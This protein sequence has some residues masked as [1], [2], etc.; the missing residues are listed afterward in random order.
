MKIVLI[1]PPVADPTA[2][3]IALPLLTAVLRRSGI[4]AVPV[5]V[6]VEAFEWLF[7]RETLLDAAGRIERRRKNLEKK[8]FLRHPEP[9]FLAALR[10]GGEIARGCPARVEAS[11]SLLREPGSAT[12]FEHDAYRKAVTALERALEMVSAAYTPLHVDF[13][14][15]RTPFS[16]LT[17]GNV[18]EDARRDRNP[19][20]GYYATDLVRRIGEEEPSMVGISVAF[21]AQIQQAYTIAGILKKRFPRL[22]LTAGGPAITQFMLRLDPGE[23]PKALGPFHTVVLFE[24]EKTLVDLAGAVERG[25]RPSGVLRGEETADLS[26]LPPPDFDGLP[27]KRYF[28]PAPVLPYDLTRGCYWGKCAFCHYGLA[29]CGT[30]RYRE[31]PVETAADHLEDLSKRYG[32]TVFYLSQDTVSP[33]TALR[34]A[35]AVQERGSRWKWATDIRPE[36]SLDGR[37]CGKLAGGGALAFSF[38]VESAS[39]RVLRRIHKGIDPAAMERAV[40]NASGEGIAVEAMCF[41]DFPTETFDEAMETLRFIGRNRERLSLFICGVFEL[42]GGSPVARNP[43]AFGIGKTWHVEGDRLKTGLYFE[44]AVP[45]KTGGEKERIDGEIDR[46]SRFWRLSP[47]PWAGSLSTAHTLLWYERFGPGAFRNP[48]GARPVPGRGDVAGLPRGIQGMAR[49]AAERECRIWETL[50]FEKKRVTPELYRELA[51]AVPP[52]P[53]PRQS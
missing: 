27:L 13:V 6:N 36:R 16:L 2:P 41:T 35:G 1:Y 43:A 23:R 8:A 42:V 17:M 11:L 19:F 21:T 24:G 26:V 33:A 7:R 5:D 10:R 31:R 29:D 51:R 32:G 47:Y 38:G 48:S 3:Y 49:R 50:V 4:E 45:W 44:A 30:A 22:H 34:F 18:E 46:L 40:R 9:L 39:P 15:Y 52:E 14:R 37:A 28:S 25:E 53:L 12:F 20:H